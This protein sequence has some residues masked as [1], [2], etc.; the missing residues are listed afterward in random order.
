V[1]PANQCLTAAVTLSRDFLD[2]A[3]QLLPQRERETIEEHVLPTADDINSALQDAFKAAR[4]KQQLCEDKRWT[5]TFGRH[6]VR[7]RDEADN[8]MLWLDR[9]KQVGDVAVN[10]DPIHA[11]LP[12]AGVRLLLEVWKDS[13]YLFLTLRPIF[14]L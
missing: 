3:L 12:W 13:D 9:F 10:V 4:D 1:R 2:R 11:G 14:P 8:V 5:F 7:L 6:T